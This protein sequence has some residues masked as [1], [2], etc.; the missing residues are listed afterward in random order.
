MVNVAEPLTPSEVAVRVAAPCR[1][2]RRGLAEELGAH[3][4][5]EGDGLARAGLR[6]YEK[7]P[8]R[9]TRREDQLLDR[10]RLGV[11]ALRECLPQ[12]G[13]ERK[14]SEGHQRFL[15]ETRAD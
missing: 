1:A 6:G 11:P 12:R 2:E 14:L 5:T 8:P 9:V 13:V 15:P 7:V 3:R 10:G 4:Q